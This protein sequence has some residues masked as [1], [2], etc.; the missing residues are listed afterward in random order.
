[1]SDVIIDSLVDS[2]VVI[3]TFKKPH[4]VKNKPD[5]NITRDYKKMLQV[6]MKKEVQ[7]VVELYQT[8]MK[9]LE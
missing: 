5:C 6:K 7:A 8:K 3:Y 9:N 1:M 4:P 2:V